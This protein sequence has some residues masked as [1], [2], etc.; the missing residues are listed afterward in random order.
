MEET[1]QKMRALVK[2]LKETAHAYYDLDAP[3]ISDA[4]WDAL[5][6]Q[7]VVMERETGVVLPDSPT[8]RV[9]GQV[10]EGFAPHRHLARLWSLDK[11]HS[12]Q[13]VADW[14]T[15]LSK[16]VAEETDLPPLRYAVEYKLDGL[17]VNLTY[18]GGMLV[19]AATR[20][21]GEV[22]E[23]ILPQVRTIRS[24]PLHIG[25]TGRMEVQGEV[26]MRLSRLKAY[27]KT[28][29]E[30]LKNARNGAAGAL[31][32]LDPKV[33]A[34]RGLSAFFYQVGY[35]EG[36]TFT[37]HVEMMAF[38]REN[39]LPT[40]EY[41][42]M[43]DDLDQA[44]AHIREIEA[45]R[46]TLDYLID[47]AVLKVDDYRT[48]EVLGYTDK[49]PRWA[50]AYK[51]PAQETTT[52]LLDVTWEVGRTGKL[53]PLAHLDPVDIGGVTVG[54]ATLNNWADIGRKEVYIGAT[55]WV[56]RSGDVIPEIMGTVD[57]EPE[58]GKAV[59]LPTHCPACGTLLTE[60]GANLFCE[61]REN[62]RPQVVG[63]LAHY[64]S[65]N[66]LDIESF[67]EKTAALFYDAFG[68][69]WPAGLYHL[70]KDAMITLKGF[71]EKKADKLLSELAKS[72]DCELDAF[73]FGLGILGV[74]RK[75]ARDLAIYFGSFSA[76]MAADEEVLQSIDAVGPIVAANVTGYFADAI[77]RREVEALLAAGVSPREMRQQ[78]A[79]HEGIFAGQ[80]V[81]L[82]GTLPTLTRTEAEERILAQGG[83]V[84]SAVSKHTSL[85]LAGEK[86]G[87]KL[88]KAESLGIEVIDEA[89]FL[90]RL[91]TSSLSSPSAL[92]T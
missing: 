56:R 1:Q 53:T 30:P 76:L 2:R 62:C 8:H 74:G 23:A 12:E 28:A 7:L 34:E 37:D 21:N 59:Q 38:I 31:R 33:T 68:L 20:G 58:K 41:F 39:G 89:E 36:K 63:R 44:M 43:A 18:E 49:F 70:Q 5:Y 61:N 22:G 26:I 29:A 92:S 86:A 84:G 35:I 10:M 32:N 66:A 47:G 14:I 6:D 60:R 16:R 3:T 54:R 50:L 71:G 83:K 51:F 52:E 75:T 40:S 87:G 11:A 24:V 78:Q 17:S 80:T 19:Q 15:R 73:L 25:F 77:Y 79:K 72:K 90:R 13:A 55:V 45:Q 67:S 64:A 42:A 82:T 91:G 65:R 69:R 88:A 4:Q 27:N 81:V 9:G 46:E 57:P 48:R 85:V